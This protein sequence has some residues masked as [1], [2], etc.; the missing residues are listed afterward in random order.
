MRKP[1]FGRRWRIRTMENL[2][3]FHTGDLV[4][5]FKRETLDL[6]KPKN[7]T[8]Y[9]YRIIGVATHS[10]T[11][12]ALMIYQALYDDMGLFARPYDMFMEEVDHE[13]YPDIR[14]RYRF[15]KTD[16]RIS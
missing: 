8:R 1:Y 16:D 4:R 7:K 11:R 9:L 3:T 12:E 13:K 14:Q 6:T 15:E 10:E 5:H 2:R